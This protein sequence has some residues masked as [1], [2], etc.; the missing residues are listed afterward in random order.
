MKI[1]PMLPTDIVAVIAID[2]AA[3]ILLPWT[4]NQYARELLK[5]ETTFCWVAEVDERLAGSLTFWNVAGEGEI[6][7][8]AVHP[9]FWRQGIGRALMKT[10]LA[11]AVELGF[12]CVLLEVRACNQPA[13]Q[14]YRSFSF[15]EDGRRVRYYSNGEAAV[16]MSLKIGKEENYV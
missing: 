14:L 12:P 11:K 3:G 7:N 13:Q 4:P 1:R 15:A 2:T 16:L 6:A 9:D 8:L 10:A 5:R